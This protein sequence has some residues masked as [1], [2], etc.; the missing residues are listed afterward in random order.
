MSFAPKQILHL[1]STT[2]PA[3]IMASLSADPTYGGGFGYGRPSRQ[4]F[5]VQV[6]RAGGSA[7]TGVQFQI[8]VAR[9]PAS[10]IWIPILSVR[11]GDSV[12]LAA[13]T[14]ELDLS[15]GT[16]AE[17]VLITENADGMPLV[18]LVAQSVTANAA[19]GDS[20]TGWIWS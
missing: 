16:T 2:T 4:Q 10:P 11:A 18:R 17:D 1:T 8:Q 13:Q 7:M 15:A 12:G 3:L 14:Q 9:D 6:V 19:T 5:F 20:V